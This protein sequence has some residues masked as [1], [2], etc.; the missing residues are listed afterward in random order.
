MVN[1]E[2]AGLDL[3]LV[4]GTPWGE[5]RGALVKNIVVSGHSNI[6]EQSFETSYAIVSI[7]FEKQ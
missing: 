7:L 1:N 6:E 2:V 4:K 5:E 3:K